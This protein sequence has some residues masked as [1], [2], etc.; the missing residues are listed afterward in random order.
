[1]RPRI[2]LLPAIMLVCLAG[3]P[4]IAQ[5]PATP[6]HP[7]HPERSEAAADTGESPL[8]EREEL[9]IAALEGLMMTPPERALP[10]LRKVLTGPMDD[11]VKARALFVLAQIDGAEAQTLLLDTARAS[12]GTLQGEAVRAI[13]IGGDDTALDAL[14]GLYA[15][16]DAS[17][18]QD[19]LQAYMIAGRKD[20]VFAIAK[21]AKNEDELEDAVQMLG[22]MDATEELRQLGELHTG[23]DSLM[24]AYA[25]AGDLDSLRRI[26]AEP[27]E[28]AVRAVR[29]IGI[30][31]NDA[32]RD[33]LREI[34]RTNADAQVKDAALQGMM[35]AGD[36][37]GVLELY[38]A[39]TNGEEKKALMRT[40]TVMGG[41]AAIE[42]MDAALQGDR[43]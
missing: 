41:D 16:G 1:M 13:G 18:K 19:I 28:N 40:L 4:V 7:S 9:A 3:A 27:G 23:S 39:S 36:E 14:A 11:R 42:A 21:D 22:V 20:A 31:G 5:T 15:S 30:V 17:V 6:E 10:L 26:A 32:A 12:T 38:R 35:I 34:Y 2:L 29:S 37:A 25:I 24:Q 43:S 33:A 8:S